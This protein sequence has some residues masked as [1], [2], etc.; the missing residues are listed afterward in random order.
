MLNHTFIHLPGIDSATEESLWA[1]GVTT[2]DALEQDEAGRERLVRE[3]V[4]ESRERLAARD[5]GYFATLMPSHE[6][7]R[8]YPEFWHETAFLDIETTGLGGD[9]YT[10][11]CGVLDRSG[12][13]AFCRGDELDLLVDYLEQFRLIVTFNGRS[14]DVPF[15]RRELGQGL[16]RKAGHMDLMHVLRRLGLKGGLKRIEKALGVGRPSALSTLDGR[17]AVT[18]WAMS[19]EG[20]QEALDTLVRYNAEDVLVLPRLAAIAVRDHSA[21]TPMAGAELEP[22]P[23]PDI[24]V[25]P[26]DP[27]IVH[28]LA[29]RRGRGSSLAIE[30]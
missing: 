18:L 7:W 1:R 15:L 5:A 9:A 29:S 24:S 28:H 20:E 4:D 2:W 11:V 17:D 6:S 21:G 22:F 14:F 30:V 10:T 27:S 23:E 12:F 19:Q 25:L 3:A 16:L 26:F 8:L 13:S